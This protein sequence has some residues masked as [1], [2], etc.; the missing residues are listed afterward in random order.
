[1]FVYCRM[2]AIS[3]VRYAWALVILSELG[4]I[5]IYALDRNQDFDLVE[6]LSVVY[7]IS[8]LLVCI[9]VLF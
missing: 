9:L 1:M 3:P 4:F 6:I 5:V 2:G 8:V 7:A